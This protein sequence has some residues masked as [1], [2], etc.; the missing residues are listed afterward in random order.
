M[1]PEKWVYPFR[2]DV[3]VRV[4]R[5]IQDA[6]K[7]ARLSQAGL[8][9]RAKTSQ[10]AV[11]RYEAGTATPSL[12]TLGR[13]LAASGSSLVLRASVRPSRVSERRIGGRRALLQRSR[14]QLLEAAQRHG[15]RNIRVFGSV[16]RGDE[17]ADSDI[18]L[19]VELEPDRTLLD[20]I[21]FQQDAQDILGIRVEAATPRFMKGRVRTRAVREA[22]RV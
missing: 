1:R 12:A 21:G 6:R 2:Y 3:Q 22:R 14:G 4:A 5:L 8:A 19:L 10:P 7:R 9:A 11:A 15:V 17:T 20:L 13:L 16:A 18:D